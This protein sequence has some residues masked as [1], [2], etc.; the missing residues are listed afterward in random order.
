MERVEQYFQ[1]QYNS[2][3]VVEGDFEEAEF[4]KRVT[5]MEN[6]MLCHVLG[7]EEIKRAVWAIGANKALGLDGFNLFFH[8]KCW[9]IISKDPIQAIQWFS[10][11]GRMSRSANNVLVS[12]VPN[13]NSV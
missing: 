13:S 1:K 10:R 3:S 2:N 4:R 6:M 11:G 9:D 8:H 12:L 5:D 7:M